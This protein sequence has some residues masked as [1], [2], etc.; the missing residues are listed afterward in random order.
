MEA[1]EGAQVPGKQAG[2]AWSEL[3]VS[4]LLRNSE[5]ENLVAPLRQL[6][7][8]QGS[9]RNGPESEQKRQSALA[10]QHRWDSCLRRRE[11]LRGDIE[12]GR[13][14]LKQVKA[15]MQ[16]LRSRL[17]DWPAHE[18]IYGRNPVMDYLNSIATH[19]RLEAFLPVWLRRR[20][21]QLQRLNQELESCARENGLEH[22]L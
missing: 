18:R 7:L 5:V 6:H 21:A 14:Y 13:E 11:S 2:K 22:L 1:I 9:R 15:E 4:S 8:D 20:E 16:D 3:E 12:R 17:E 10:L 19:E